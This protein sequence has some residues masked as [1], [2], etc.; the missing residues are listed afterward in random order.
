[1]V[2]GMFGMF[3]LGALYLQR[4]LGYDPM[5]IGLAFMPVAV[6]I[7]TLSF[8]LS[9]QLNTRFGARTMLLIG[10]ALVTAGLALFARAPLQARYAY[11]VLPSMVLLGVGGGLSFPAVMTLGMSGATDRDSGLISG[12]V[13]TTAQVGG[14]LGLAVLATLATSRTD[15]LLAAGESTTSAL[16]A[17]YHLAFGIGAGFLA[18]AILVAAIVLRP[19]VAAW[20]ETSDAGETETSEEAA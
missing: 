5:Q 1:M 4:I 9:A 15:Q 17:G 2:A 20:S 18:A 14:S 11:D 7:G 3:F 16:I 13:N 8:R 6:A 12:L 19:E 10:L